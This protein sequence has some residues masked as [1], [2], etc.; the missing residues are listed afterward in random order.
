[1]NK[2][3]LDL[4]IPV[5]GKDPKFVYENFVEIVEKIPN[6]MG[7]IFVY[8]NSEDGI[9]KNY[10]L[11]KSFARENIIVKKVPSNRLK[12]SKLIEAFKMS[13]SEWIMT[14]DSHHK[15]DLKNIEDLIHFL[16]KSIKIN[17]VW[18][19]HRW[20]DLDKGKR[21][22]Y[23]KY[24][25]NYIFSA[26]KYILRSSLL[27]NIEKSI[28]YD[29]IYG[30]DYTFG[31]YASANNVINSD[32][33]KKEF[34]VRTFGKKVSGTHN[35]ITSDRNSKESMQK[36]F[37]TIFTHFYKTYELNNNNLINLDFKRSLYFLYKNLYKVSFIIE[38]SEKKL[39]YN[40]SK[41][42]NE[43]LFGYESENIT[44]MISQYSNDSYIFFQHYRY[45]FK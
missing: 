28:D 16:E 1:M 11:L 41:V 19:L 2:R 25:I 45:K 15:I 9:E 32:Y 10:D 30:D 36:D 29:V 20:E 6:S 7:I 24:G 5:Y 21:Y 18:H 12:T 26:G 38:N 13:E 39:S 44:K 33:Y 42:I 40:K 22:I 34:Y 3:I 23:G 14:V 35:W 27:K 4:L 17:L 43:I 8:K 37:L 31:L